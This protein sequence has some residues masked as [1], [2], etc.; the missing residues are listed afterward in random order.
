MQKLRLLLLQEAYLLIGMLTLMKIFLGNKYIL[1]S[2]KILDL[3]T[4]FALQK[5][6][7][8]L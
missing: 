6:H 1:V 5:L 2:L 7:S 8:D 3:C 4:A